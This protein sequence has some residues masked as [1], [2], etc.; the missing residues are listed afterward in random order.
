MA[1]RAVLPEEI[2]KL[3]PNHYGEVFDSVGCLQ[4]KTKDE[5]ENEAAEY[6]AM[7]ADADR[8]KEAQEWCNA[9][10]GPV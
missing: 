5:Y 9:S 1:D 10:F 7:A 4:K 8:E 6:K 3:S 2:Y